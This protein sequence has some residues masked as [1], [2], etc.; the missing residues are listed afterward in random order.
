MCISTFISP[1]FDMELFVCSCSEP[2]LPGLIRGHS[3]EKAP[4]TIIIKI[5]II[6]MLNNNNN[7]NNSNDNLTDPK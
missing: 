5:I 4:G 2:H 7:S 3:S 1:V 6:I